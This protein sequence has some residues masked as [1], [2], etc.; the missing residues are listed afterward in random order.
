MLW[1]CSSDEAFVP[2][3][4]SLALRGFQ[5]DRQLK[6]GVSRTLNKECPGTQAAQER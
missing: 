6:Y 3:G 5:I 1:E 4:M 2:V